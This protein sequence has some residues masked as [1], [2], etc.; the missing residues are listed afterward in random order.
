MTRKVKT[1]KQN[2][3]KVLKLVH[4]TQAYKKKSLNSFNS[5]LKY[6]CPKMSLLSALFLADQFSR[7][8]CLSLLGDAIPNTIQSCHIVHSKINFKEKAEKL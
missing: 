4:Q 7:I 2:N 1:N 5:Y 8:P 6:H 3:N